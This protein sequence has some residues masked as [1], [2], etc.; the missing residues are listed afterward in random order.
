MRGHLH[1]HVGS[2]LDKQ[3]YKFNIST[4]NCVMEGNDATPAH[5]VGVSPVGNSRKDLLLV[6]LGQG[7]L[8]P[9]HRLHMQIL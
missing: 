1:V 4:F 6:S 7:H 8:Q 3:R 2:G 5:A 9:F